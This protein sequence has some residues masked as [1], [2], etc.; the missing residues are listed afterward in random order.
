MATTT[1]VR[2]VVA[3]SPRRSPAPVNGPSAKSSIASS[4]GSWWSSSSSTPSFPSSG[5]SSP[6]SSRTPSSSRRRSTTGRRQINWT[7]YQF[8]LDNG[9][10]LRALRNSV[11]VSVSTVLI[12]LAFGSLC[13]YA[14]GRMQFRGRTS[15]PVPHPLDDDVPADRHPRLALPDDQ[16]GSVSSTGLPALIIA[17]LT[18]TLPFTVWVLDQLLQGDAR[19]AGGSGAGRWGDAVPGVHPHSPAA[20]RARVW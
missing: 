16:R 12:S 3:G 10:F 9:D 4:S 13:A 5:R 2:P 15:S 17:Y 11:I 20:C 1:A 6:R 8:V 14:M 19:R 7:F 18:F